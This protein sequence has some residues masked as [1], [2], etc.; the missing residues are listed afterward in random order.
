MKRN[1]DP[2][3]YYENNEEKLEYE[4]R[5]EKKK[6]AREQDERRARECVSFANTLTTG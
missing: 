6:R 4:I 2:Y 1:I 5:E 3:R